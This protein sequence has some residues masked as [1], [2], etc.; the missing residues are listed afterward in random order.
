MHTLGLRIGIGHMLGGGGGGESFVIVLTRD[1]TY[2]FHHV[3]SVEVWE[4]SINQPAYQSKYK[5][6][7]LKI[8]VLSRFKCSLKYPQQRH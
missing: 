2:F 7:N 4:N 3:G 5:N 8:I 1:V 6:S